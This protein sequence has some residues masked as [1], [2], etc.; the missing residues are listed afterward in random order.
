MLVWLRMSRKWLLLAVAA[1]CTADP[2]LPE[3]DS[4]VGYFSFP[5]S[6]PS[7][8][9]LLFV[10]DNS[11]AIGPYSAAL[12]AMLRDAVIAID[13]LLVNRSAMRSQRCRPSERLAVL[14]PNRSRRFVDSR[15]I[16]RTWGSFGKLRSWHRDRD[17]RR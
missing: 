6:P 4:R 11:P 1:G 13:N 7:A 2:T 14:R 12:S 5:V 8:V 15:P 9:D 3:A 10:L 17:G 16:Q